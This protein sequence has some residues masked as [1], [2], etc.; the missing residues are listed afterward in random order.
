VDFH[1]FSTI[2]Q[3]DFSQYSKMMVCETTKWIIALGPH[4]FKSSAAADGI[5]IFVV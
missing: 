2:F 5:I 1:R 4:H 3:D